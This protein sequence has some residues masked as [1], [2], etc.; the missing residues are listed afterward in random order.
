MLSGIGKARELARHGIPLVQDLPGV[1]ENLQDHLD[2][3]LEYRAKS[4]APYGIS[5]KALPRNILH[6]LDWIFRKR[7][8]FSSTTAEGGGF[9]STDP[10]SDRPDIQLFF[11]TGRANTQ[12]ASGFTGHGFL[13]HI[14]QL[15]PGS[16]GRVALKSADPAEPAVDPLQ[17]LPRRK[18]MDVLRAGIRLAR[19][20]MAQKPFAPHLDAEVD[21]GPDVESDGA[22]MPSSANASARCSIR[23][24]PARWV[25]ADKRWSI[26]KRCASTVSEG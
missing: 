14:C 2:I 6:V 20:I 22:S 5:W 1:G 17:F 11:C 13:M 15:R 12:A 10:N 16:I 24:A 7:G 4:I 26:P 23:S 21:P 18:H 19:K 9:L 3:T 8:L 25:R